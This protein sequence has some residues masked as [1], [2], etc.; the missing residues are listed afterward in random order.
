MSLGIVLVGGGFLLGAVGAFL[1]IRP[2]MFAGAAICF[3]GV[4][5][6]TVAG[7]F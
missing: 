5:L 7:F 3:V 2:A 1:M 4:A 6:A